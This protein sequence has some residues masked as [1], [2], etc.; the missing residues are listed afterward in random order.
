M[1]PQV[2]TDITAGPLDTVLPCSSL[3]SGCVGSAAPAHADV[4]LLSLC[5]LSGTGLYYGQSNQTSVE[6]KKME[7]MDSEIYAYMHFH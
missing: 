5:R 6:M 2:V 3:Q 7:M 1:M 4:W